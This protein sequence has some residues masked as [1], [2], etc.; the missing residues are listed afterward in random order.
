MG[1]TYPSSCFLTKSV[2]A[3]RNLAKHPDCET[4]YKKADLNSSTMP[5]SRKE[6]KGVKSQTKLKRLNWQ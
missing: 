2:K 3:V 4:F 6:K 1:S 5:M